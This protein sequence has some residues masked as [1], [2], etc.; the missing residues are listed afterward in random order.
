MGKYSSVNVKSLLSVTNT[1]ISELSSHNLNAI[2]ISLQNQNILMSQASKNVS[3]SL[4]NIINSK[5]INGSISNLKD[6]LTN[7]KKACEYI[8][9]CQSIEEEIFQLEKKL[10]KKDGKKSSSIQSQINSKKNTLASYE[11]KV[12][13]QLR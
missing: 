2:H 7:L 1:A 8:E 12:D 4:N 5:N 13:D 10:Y 9:K 11:R 6:K 3:L